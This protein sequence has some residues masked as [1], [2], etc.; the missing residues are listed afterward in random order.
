MITAKSKGKE[1]KQKGGTG[2]E[3]ERDE[4]TQHRQ[5]NPGDETSRD[6]KRCRLKMTRK[7]QQHPRFRL[8]DEPLSR[9]TSS[10]S[11]M[12]PFQLEPGRPRRLEGR[13]IA[14]EFSSKVARLRILEASL[15]PGPPYMP[16]SPY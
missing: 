3:R 15:A 8:D 6:Q 13:C 7:S 10:H 16:P 11:R 12:P 14:M 4:E 5:K 2:R 1:R 9:N